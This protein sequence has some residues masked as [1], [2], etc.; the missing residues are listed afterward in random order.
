MATHLIGEHAS[1]PSLAKDAGFFWR[2]IWDHPQNA[3]LKAK[4]RDPN[5]L[6]AGDEV[7]VPEREVKSCGRTSGARHSFKRLGDPLRFKLQLRSMGE[8]RRGEDYV[9][10]IGAT[11]IRGKTDGDGNLETFLPGNTRSAKLL[12]GGGKEEYTLKISRLDPIEDLSGVQQR[13]NNLGF[14]CGEEKGELTP[15]TEQAL[16]SFQAQHD[17]PVTGKADGP[18][19]RKLESLV[20]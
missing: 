11:R 15:R 9:L 6:R 12:L 19:R 3:A 10:Q 13:L 7:F 20:A 5:V 18:T 8:P 16:R 1:I 2:T 17:L 4:R 14:A